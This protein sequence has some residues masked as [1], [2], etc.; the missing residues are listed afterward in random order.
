MTSFSAS[1]TVGAQL[2]PPRRH[3]WNSHHAELQLRKLRSC[4]HVETSACRC[5]TTGM[6]ESLSKNCNSGTST[7]FCDAGPGHLCGTPTGHVILSR[8]CNSGISMVSSKVRAM[9]NKLCAATGMWM[10]VTC[11]TS[12]SFL[13][14]PRTRA[15]VVAHNWH[16]NLVQ[17]QHLGDLHGKCTVCTVRTCCSQRENCRS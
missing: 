5:T 13:N 4:L 12:T 3:P 15:P 16:N 10:T 14:C 9:G 8:N 6:S 2:F 7:V 11:G 17:E 1:A